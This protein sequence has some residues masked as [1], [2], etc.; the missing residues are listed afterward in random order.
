MSLF[1][2]GTESDAEV[3]VTRVGAHRVQPV[4]VAGVSE[5]CNHSLPAP[6]EEGADRHLPWAIL[7]QSIQRQHSCCTSVGCWLRRW[8]GK[9]IVLKWILLSSITTILLLFWAVPQRILGS[10]LCG[11]S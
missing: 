2:P 1:L 7:C 9:N 10:F 11:V 6:G 4:L 3:R 8:F 5:Q